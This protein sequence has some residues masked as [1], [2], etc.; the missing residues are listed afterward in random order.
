MPG[1]P[2]QVFELLMDSKKHAAITGDKA[3][4]GRKVG[5]T[6]TTFDGWATGKTIELVKDKK[7][8]QLWRGSDWPTGHYSTATFVILSAPKG[9][10][11]L[12]FTQTEIPTTFAKDVSQ[13]WREYYWEPMKAAL[14]DR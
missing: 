5:S 4:I 7:I 1:T 6:F 3:K 11:K 8:V 12:L 2:H 14:A 9:G 10:T 13:G